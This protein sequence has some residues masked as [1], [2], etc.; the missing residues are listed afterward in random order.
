MSSRPLLFAHIE[1][2][3]GT[4]VKAAVEARI[5]RDKI[6][7]YEAEEDTVIRASETLV[8]HTSPLVN[9]VRATIRKSPLL[10][11]IRMTYLK[12]RDAHEN[13]SKTSA[14]T[15]PNE[16]EVIY[17]N[18]KADRFDGVVDNPRLVTV[19]RDPLART[20]SHFLQ[21][22][23]TR[24]TAVLRDGLAYDSSTSF[25]EFAFSDA[26]QNFQS[27]TLGSKQLDD[28]E[29][30]GVTEHLGKFLFT[31]DLVNEESTTLRLNASPNSDKSD[32]AV[33]D[34]DV[35][36]R[37]YEAANSRDYELYFSALEQI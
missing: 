24:G 25:E 9:A 30:V 18:F 1:K 23:Q 16:F 20:V 13:G 28:F 15:P 7:I 36:Q 6:L 35:F 4:T 32:L 11:P 26:M 31:L 34:S 8:N 3:G 29:H 17:G 37:D 33:L 2:T 27:N 22:R 14:S 19:F 10:L 21:W 5:P 12:L